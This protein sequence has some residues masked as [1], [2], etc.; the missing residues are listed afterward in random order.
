MV[1]SGLVWKMHFDGAVNK[2]GAGL[3]VVL[4]TPDGELVLLSKRLTF[5]VTNNAAEYE[6]CLFG[7]EALSKVG[8]TDVEVYGDSTIVIRQVM[9]DW[10]IREESLHPYVRAVCELS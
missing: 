6:A 3:G 5:P 9:G 10:E 2:N 4:Y 7:L 8:A 1:I